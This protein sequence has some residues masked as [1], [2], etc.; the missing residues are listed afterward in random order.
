MWWHKKSN[1]KLSL[2]HIEVEVIVGM[3]AGY[4]I[5]ADYFC[6]C[7]IYNHNKSVCIASNSRVSIT[8]GF[9]LLK[10]GQ[11][12][13]HLQRSLPTVS[14]DLRGAIFMGEHAHRCF[15]FKRSQPA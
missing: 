15:L 7:K 11:F 14:I 8:F 10:W 2:Y 3:C 9:H 12:D 6:Q 13:G 1:H 5:N 4:W